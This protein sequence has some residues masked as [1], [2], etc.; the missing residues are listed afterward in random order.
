MYTCMC[1]CE[2]STIHAGFIYVWKH[3]I[4][5]HTHTQKYLNTFAKSGS[6]VEYVHTITMRHVQNQTPKLP[7]HTKCGRPH[8]WSLSA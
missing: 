5:R 8:F 6:H 1:S 7:S 2:T 4:N 3:T